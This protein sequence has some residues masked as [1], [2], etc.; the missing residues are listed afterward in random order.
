MTY[1]D[2]A[3]RIGAPKAARAVGAAVGKN[4]ISFVVPCHRVLGKSGDIT[5]YYWGLTRKRAMLGWE[6]G[7]VG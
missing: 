5:G 1:S 3:A 7:R 4:P 6:L 2:V